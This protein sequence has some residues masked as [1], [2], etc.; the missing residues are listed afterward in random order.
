MLLAVHDPERASRPSCHNLCK[1][2]RLTPAEGRV[3]ER[4]AAGDSPHEIQQRLGLSRNTFRTHA[5]RLLDKTGAKHRGA[6]IRL[7]LTNTFV[8]PPYA[9]RTA[10]GR[11]GKTLA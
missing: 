3:A 7:L 9:P 5:Q 10:T 2:Y 1:S 11:R 8:P 6:L 4:L